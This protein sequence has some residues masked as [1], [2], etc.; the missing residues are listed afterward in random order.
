MQHFPRKVA[1]RILPIFITTLAAGITPSC[2]GQQ[3]TP[4]SSRVL[5]GPGDVGPMLAAAIKER[6]PR[7]LLLDSH[8]MAIALVRKLHAL[9]Y[10][11]EIV[12]GRLLRDDLRATAAI[13]DATA[14]G[15]IIR[16]ALSLVSPDGMA[17]LSAQEA[18][19]RDKVVGGDSS[20]VLFASVGSAVQWSTLSPDGMYAEEPALRSLWQ[21]SRYLDVYWQ[22]MTEDEQGALVGLLGRAKRTTINFR[23]Q[24]L[25][26]HE[27]GFWHENVGRD[28]LLLQSRPA[29]TREPWAHL[30]D[31]LGNLGK[32]ECN[33]LRDCV[34]EACRL[35]I[36]SEPKAGWWFHVDEPCEMA[37]RRQCATYIYVGLREVDM[38][39]G[40]LL[41]SG[42]TRNPIVLVEPK[43]D[44]WKQWRRCFE[45]LGESAKALAV[46]VD[47]YRR[48]LKLVDLALRLLDIEHQRRVNAEASGELYDEIIAYL[49]T[50][51]K[52]GSESGATV[53]IESI[54]PMRRT[55]A[56]LVLVPV[57]V[58]GVREEAVALRV[59]TEVRASSGAWE[60]PY[61][62]I[63]G[64]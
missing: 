10:D 21:V 53:R 1:N 16:V 11:A 29:D 64:K 50:E 39:R 17:T 58:D 8:V 46:D 60:A 37:R 44:L 62:N 48:E 5:Y 3:P 15:S 32:S 7:Y 51:L 13:A 34:L 61:V 31:V 45:K 63:Q 38:T 19:E 43:P 59:A 14:A 40:L 24:V 54:G 41:R 20:P 36:A 26:A 22:L 42:E 49:L 47:Y 57:S 55:G 9:V 30:T 6:S 27:G 2:L 25:F 4:S 28:I 12:R 52:Y 23:S 18:S 33:H 35:V 56:Y